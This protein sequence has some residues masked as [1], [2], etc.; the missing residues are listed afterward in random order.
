MKS[1]GVI[2]EYN[3]F[4]NGHAFHLEEAKK[5]TDADVVLAAMS[6]NFLQRGEPALVSKWTRAKMA[7][8]AGV[9][10]VF[11][12]PYQYA[13]QQAEIFANGSVS[14]LGAA[15]CDSICFG[16]E[17]GKIDAFED[18]YLFMQKNDD[19]F[20]QRV[21]EHSQMGVSYPK[22]LSLAFQDLGAN[23]RMIDLS[24]PNNILGFQYLKAAKRLGRHVQILTVTRKNA[25]YHDEDFSSETIASATS[26]R[27]ALFSENGEL[28]EIQRFVPISTYEQLVE[29]KRALGDFHHWEQYFPYLK[30]RL[31]QSSPAE[32]KTI[33]EVEEGIENRLLS[34]VAGAV[35]FSEFM[36]R[37][38]TKRYTWTRLQRICLH[39][40]V[41][42]KK[43]E[44]AVNG[45]GVPYLRLLGMTEKGR[46]YLNRRKN[47]FSAPLISNVS[48][49]KGREMDLDLRAAKIY[50]LGLTKNNPDLE[51]EYKKTPI[52][53][54]Q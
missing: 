30:F 4:H 18:T 40:L 37:I 21:R 8:S 35:T 2:V 38:K 36:S 48:S 12:L 17:S 15:G 13:T 41:N 6:G 20:Q 24:K 27:K 26:I 19:L 54:K 39:I 11:E 25:G 1:V 45:E 3:P 23:D 33:Y 14:L 52:Y 16:S 34:H 53:L 43:T 29:Y 31:L 7:L 10:I 22:A 46:E 32:L 42:A 28:D 5:A 9:D 51:I 50:Q 49:Y 44:M 47:Q